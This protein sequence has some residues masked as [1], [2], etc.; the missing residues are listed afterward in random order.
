M[1]LRPRRSFA[2]EFTRT[3][4][5]DDHPRAALCLGDDASHAARRSFQQ[6]R[7]MDSHLTTHP[8]LLVRICNRQDHDAWMQFVKLYAPPIFRFLKR[9]GLQDADAADLAQEVFAAVALW[10]ERLKYDRQ[11]GKFRG[12]L[13]A[14]TRHKLSNFI[15]RAQLPDKATGDAE[16][17]RRL[18]SQPAPQPEMLEDRVWDEEYEMC[19]LQWAAEKVRVDFRGQ[20]WEAFWQTRVEGRSIEEVAIELGLTHGA[21]YIARCRVLKRLREE[22]QLVEELPA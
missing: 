4:L 3:A 19:L 5:H 1:G 6:H 16:V 2:L 11:R 17:R 18:E 20:T 22:I 13:F 9:H 12:W 21:V 15:H 8:S 14:L 10:I 7:A